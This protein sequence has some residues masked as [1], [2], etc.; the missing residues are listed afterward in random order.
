M[1]SQRRSYFRMACDMNIGVRG[2]AK[3]D[4]A[5]LRQEFW[6]AHSGDS[7]LQGRMARL[8]FE[9]QQ[10]LSQ[11]SQRD[12]LLGAYLKVLESRMAMVSDLA[13]SRDLGGPEA[14]PALVS[15]SGGGV[16]L[17]MPTELTTGQMVDLT[18]V[19]PDSRM[20][21]RALGRVARCVPVAGGE[22]QIGITFEEMP[23][24]AREAIVQY[25]FSL[26]SLDLKE[27]IR[28]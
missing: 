23:E 17:I 5:A 27:R 9:A 7:S 3:V 4:E 18:L 24:G 22:Y 26:Q 14:S 19:L 15:L 13:V 21:N 10:L 12:Q 2:I 20:S 8:E 25:L 16:G 28:A 6:A 11:L 1:T